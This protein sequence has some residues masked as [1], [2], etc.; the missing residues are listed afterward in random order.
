MIR[1]RTLGVAVLT[2]Y[3]LTIVAGCGK[4]APALPP[5]DSMDFTNFEKGKPN[6]ALAAADQAVSTANVELAAASVG[7]VALAVNLYLAMP[8]LIFWGVVSEKPTKDG[9]TWRWQHA[10]PLMGVDATLSGT[11]G[12]SLELQM[13]VTGS[14]DMSYVQD[15]LWYTGSHQANNGRWELYDPGTP[16]EPGPAEPVLGIDWAKDSDTQ[17]SLVFTNIR[18][19]SLKNGDTLTFERDGTIASMSIHDALSGQND[20][21]AATD[22]TV[23]WNLDNGAGRLTRITGEDLC[24]DTMTAGQADIPCPAGGWPLP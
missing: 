11:R 5:N 15:F 21:G 14:R 20:D 3:G 23:A 6:G 18:P 10:F 17:K 7:F 19:Q 1:N 2:C 22:F 12:A 13:R 9:D 16:T 4:E 24:W 8:R